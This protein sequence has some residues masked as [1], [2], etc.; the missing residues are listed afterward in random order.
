MYTCLA[1][2]DAGSSPIAES[3]PLM[4]ASNE[5]ATIKV[6]PQNLIAR[7]GEQ[8][9]MHCVYDDADALQWYHKDV[10]LDSDDERAI[11]DNGTLI[12]RS[13]EQHRDQGIYSCHG[14]KGET[15]QIYTAELQIACESLSAHFIL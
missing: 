12:I 14:V 15:V 3:F 2:N 4:I 10:L 11:L 8:A 9:V 1:K 5:T 7:R 13:T 6:V